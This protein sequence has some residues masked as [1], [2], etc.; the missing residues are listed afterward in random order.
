MRS[1]ELSIVQPRNTRWYIAALIT[2]PRGTY[3]KKQKS[4]PW[5]RGISVTF[6]MAVLIA[7]FRHSPMR[8]FSFRKRGTPPIMIR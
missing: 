2:E 7:I 3:A 4:K 5:R 8:S 6:Q 1:W